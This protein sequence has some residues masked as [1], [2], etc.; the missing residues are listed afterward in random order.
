MALERTISEMVS[1]CYST[2]GTLEG[3]AA[4]WAEDKMG[5]APS[6]EEEQALFLSFDIFLKTCSYLFREKTLFVS[7]IHDLHQGERFPF[8]P[9]WK[10]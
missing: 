6:I 8:D 7:H 3:E 5:K 9:L 1:E 2:V 10:L 4:V